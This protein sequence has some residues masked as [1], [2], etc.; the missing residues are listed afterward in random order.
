MKGTFPI[1]D[2]AKEHLRV[3]L[4]TQNGEEQLVAVIFPEVE[5]PPG[6]RSASA[7]EMANPE[8]LAERAEAH[9]ASLPR[10][11]LAKWSVGG[12]RRSRFPEGDIHEID[13]VTFFLPEDIKARVD[14]RTL[15]VRAGVLEFE[16]ALDPFVAEE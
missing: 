12:A 16:P 7:D 8:S 3:L 13:G 1:T 11:L 14:G 6:M 2:V 5:L 15:D 4:S 9:F 10:P